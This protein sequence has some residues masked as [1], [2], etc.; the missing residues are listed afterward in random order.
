MTHTLGSLAHG[1]D[2][3]FNL[4]RAV[5]A[6]AVLV[7]HAHP[8]ALGEGAEEPLVALTGHS[9]GGLSVWAFF[10]ISGFL[11][12]M[13]F[14]RS[15]TRTEFLL[16]RVLRL[17]PGLFVSLMLV[18]FLMGPLVTA[19]PPA[20][21]LADPATWSFVPR[22]M[23][24]LPLQY[25]LPGVFDDTPYQ[26]VE[27]SIWTLFHEVMCYAGVFLAGL[28]GLVARRGAMTLAIAA[29]LAIWFGVAAGLAAEAL[30][31][32]GRI[33]SFHQLSLPFVIGMAFYAWRD[34][35]PLHFGILA[36]LAGLTWA[37]GGTLFYDPMLALTLSYGVFWVAYVPAGAI[38]A[39]NRIGD[40]SYGI[41]I[42]AF[43]VQGLMV[44]LMGP[45]TP[46]F[47]MMT[48]FPLTLALSVASWHLVESPALAQRKPLAA[49]LKR[50]AA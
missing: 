13:S 10:A 29:Y 26:A 21:Y 15:R 12:T 24:L 38:R 17:F 25:T 45:Q 7:S 39:Y 48:A 4:V 34:R 50:Q 43:P 47:N 23:A 31:L 5:A 22:N 3:N 6:T 44:W 11:I 42:Y 1:R 9:L 18:A 37:L 27:G 36:A 35:L 19:L 14:A 20:A 49:R 33:V 32:P 46:L 40:Y 28:L 16:A 41:Y 30:P 8:I 2:N